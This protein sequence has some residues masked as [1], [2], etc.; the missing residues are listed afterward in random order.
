M[1][2]DSGTK[3]DRPGRRGG[4]MRLLMRLPGWAYIALA[5]GGL[6]AAVTAALQ[7]VG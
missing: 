2:F 3:P 7:R 6:G 1:S 4:F 5:L